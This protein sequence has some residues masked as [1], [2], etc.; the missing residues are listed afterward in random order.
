MRILDALLQ[1]LEAQGISVGVA[2]DDKHA[3]TRASVL[4]EEV[5]FHIEERIDNV[6]IDLPPSKSRPSWAA[7]YRGE[8]SAFRR[9]RH[10]YR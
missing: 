3:T 1:A 4:G 2:V 6:T 5:S 10:L 8:A 7:D 9:T